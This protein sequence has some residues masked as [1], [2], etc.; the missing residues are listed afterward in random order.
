MSDARVI[1]QRRI[2][3]ALLLAA[4]L[5][6]PAAAQL[7]EDVP[8]DL[9]EVEVTQ[10]LEAPLPLE[11]TFTDDN[12]KPVRLGQYF[13]NGRPV[14]LTLVYYN[15]PMLCNLVLQ[16]LLDAAREMEWV[17]GH[18]FEIVTVS[19]NPRENATLARAKKQNY[20]ASYG[21]PEAAAGWHF[22]TGQPDAIRTLADAVGFQYRYVPETKEYAHPA[23]LM[24][25]TPGGR[26]SRYLFGVRHDAQTLRL[27][28]IE[29]ADGKIGSL[30]DQFVLSCFR[31]DEKKGR[32][33]PSALKLM[34]IGG[35]LS[36]VILG[37][38]LVGLWRRDARNRKRLD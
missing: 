26:V 33:G 25:I 14:V 24:V 34:R 10:R 16:G 5:V 21:R 2:A 7:A 8:E 17:P 36:A 32:Y 6:H 18:E 20:I 22:L 9:Q 35:T 13:D 3:A 23:A 38:V 15:C 1:R 28:L 30:A 27:S 11:L 12:G 31:Y 19:I 4:A 37:A 29:A